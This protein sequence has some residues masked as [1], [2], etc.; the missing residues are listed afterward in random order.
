MST[1]VTLEEAQAKLPELVANLSAGEEVLIV[2]NE[3]PIAKLVGQGAA[4][5]KPRRPGSAVGKLTILAE[6]DEHLIDFEAY[7]R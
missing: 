3:R 2:Q 4:V 1:T 5:R 7:M 6:D